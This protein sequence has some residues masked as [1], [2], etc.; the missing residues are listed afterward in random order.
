[1]GDVWYSTFILPGKLSSPRKGHSHCAGPTI[2]AGSRRASVCV[3]LFH[4]SDLE[5]VATTSDRSAAGSIFLLDDD[6]YMHREFDESANR[7]Y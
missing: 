1:M 5:L 7:E 4:R 2:N 6:L 3:I